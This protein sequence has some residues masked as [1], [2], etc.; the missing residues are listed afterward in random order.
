MEIGKLNKLKQI[1]LD[2][3]QLSGSLPLGMFNISTL[4]MIAFQGNSLSGSL[5]SSICSRLQGLSWL[6]LSINELSGMIPASLSKCS[7]LRVLG[8]SHNNFSGVMP[9]EVGN[10]TALQELYL[11]YNDLEG[12]ILTLC[13]YAEIKK[14][15]KSCI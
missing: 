15:K 8:L 12:T 10:L 13:I 6:D 3:N 9:E 4:E 2:Y 7:K 14:R 1:V 5:S 11:G